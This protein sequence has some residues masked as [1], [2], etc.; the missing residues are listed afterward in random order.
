VCTDAPAYLTGA[1]V[2]VDGAQ[3]GVGAGAAGGSE[4]R[5][6]CEERAQRGDIKLGDRAVV[7]RGEARE[8]GA[9]GAQ[10][11]RGAPGVLELGEIGSASSAT[12]G[13][14]D[15]CDNDAFKGSTDVA[16]GQ[17]ARGAAVLVAVITILLATCVVGPFVLRGRW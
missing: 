11:V 7:E 3:R 10:G 13:P 15:W 14:A 6:G 9:V 5:A 16:A 1:N 4:R 12:P 8:L 2:V 17:Q